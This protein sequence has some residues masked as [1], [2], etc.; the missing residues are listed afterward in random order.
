MVNLLYRKYF[1]MGDAKSFVRLRAFAVSKGMV[2]SKRVRPYG[3][4]IMESNVEMGISQREQR[5]CMEDL[6]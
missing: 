6:S 2:S 5:N 3:H 1:E 4:G